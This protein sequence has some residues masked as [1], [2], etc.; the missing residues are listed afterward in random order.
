MILTIVVPTFQMEFVKRG[1][2]ISRIVALITQFT[3]PRLCLLNCVVL[4]DSG[5]Q[6]GGWSCCSSSNQCNI[7]EGDCDNDSEC[8]GNLVCGTDNCGSNFTN[9]TNEQGE[10]HQ[11]DCCTQGNK[12]HIFNLFSSEM[13]PCRTAWQAYRLRYSSRQLASF[14][15]RSILESLVKNKSQFTNSP[16]FNLPFS[17]KIKMFHPHENQAQMKGWH[18]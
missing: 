9:G 16:N 3:A 4:I 2:C 5:C 17:K 7:G 14:S 1:N 6:N 10:F 18:E 12:S 15:L 11:Q 8:S 13:T